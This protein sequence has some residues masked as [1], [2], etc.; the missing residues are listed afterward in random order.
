[1]VCLGRYGDE[2]VWGKDLT[3]ADPNSEMPVGLAPD[4]AY[5]NQPLDER[6]EITSFLRP[7]LR[8]RSDIETANILEAPRY[9]L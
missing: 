6:R 1:M 8:L 5:V 4:T 3:L 9:W 2:V 7:H